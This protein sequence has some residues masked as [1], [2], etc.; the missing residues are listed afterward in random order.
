MAC[1]SAAIERVARRLLQV[2]IGFSPHCGAVHGINSAQVPRIQQL[3]D[4]CAFACVSARRVVALQHSTLRSPAVV[5]VFSSPRVLGF[6][7]T[8]EESRC[9]RCVV[10]DG[11]ICVIS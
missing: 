1:A 11:K 3:C 6:V 9:V 2:V 5:V 4:V 7:E 8:R 10:W